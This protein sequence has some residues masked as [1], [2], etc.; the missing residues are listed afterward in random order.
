MHLLCFRVFSAGFQTQKF[1]C[2][3]MPECKT[4]GDRAFKIHGLVKTRPFAGLNLNWLVPSAEGIFVQADSQ[5]SPTH[6]GKDWG[7]FKQKRGESD[8]AAATQEWKG[9]EKSVCLCVSVCACVY[10]HAHTHVHIYVVLSLFTAPP[11]HEQYSTNIFF[12]AKKL[13]PTVVRNKDFKNITQ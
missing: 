5:G 8:A 9:R 6:S 10:I 4:S 12:Q 7:R 2:W 11:I 3:S 1:M 13:K